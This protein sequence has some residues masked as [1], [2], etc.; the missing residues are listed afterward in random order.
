[1]VWALPP[2]RAVPKKLNPRTEGPL[3]CSTEE[4]RRGVDGR[5]D[6]ASRA[7]AMTKK[8]TASPSPFV[9]L[10]ACDSA[11]S[12]PWPVGSRPVYPCASGG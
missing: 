6:A 1:M 11:L 4:A 7:G 5:A 9:L 12:P 2:S 10:S 3:L 8:F